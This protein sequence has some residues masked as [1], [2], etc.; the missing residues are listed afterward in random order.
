M[1][2]KA[3]VGSVAAGAAGAEECLSGPG[4]AK[5]VF[6]FDGAGVRRR[7]IR[8]R[9]STSVMS[10]RLAFEAS[11]SSGGVIVAP[12]TSHPPLSGAVGWSGGIYVAC[13]PFT[14]LD[15]AEDLHGDRRVKRHHGLG[16]PIGVHAVDHRC[17]RESYRPETWTVRWPS[18]SCDFASSSAYRGMIISW[19]ATAKLLT[20]TDDTSTGRIA[21]CVLTPA[22]SMASCSLFRCIQVTVKIAAIMPITPQS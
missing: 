10:S 11:S 14:L 9:S 17:L 6:G 13:W 21:R 2:S 7:E 16:G 15:L 22:A 19:F 5:L 1:R 20:I 4:R 12:R 8:S 18:S 3:V